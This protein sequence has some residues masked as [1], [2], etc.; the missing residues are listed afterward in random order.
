MLIQ[1]EEETWWSLFFAIQS[2][3]RDH[4][5]DSQHMHEDGRLVFDEI[6][7]DISKYDVKK[8]KTAIKDKRKRDKELSQRLA[9]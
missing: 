2:N 5:E 4:H 3:H 9:E 8:I 7:D 1:I 6:S